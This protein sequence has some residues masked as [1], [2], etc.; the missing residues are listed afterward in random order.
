MSARRSTQPAAHEDLE[1]TRAALAAERGKPKVLLRVV[2]KLSLELQHAQEEL[3]AAQR[4]TRLPG[5]RRIVRWL[6]RPQLARQAL[7]YKDTACSGTKPWR[8]R[9]SRED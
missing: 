9:P 7:T 3:V 5:T 1:E 6:Q 4:V 2:S 8:I